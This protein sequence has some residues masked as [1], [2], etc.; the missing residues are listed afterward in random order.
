MDGANENWKFLKDGRELEI[1]K[2]SKV[3]VVLSLLIRSCISL[4]Y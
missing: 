3:E 1:G 2:A 4:L